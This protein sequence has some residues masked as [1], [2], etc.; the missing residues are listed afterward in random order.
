MHIVPKP[1][2]P[3]SAAGQQRQGGIIVTMEPRGDQ[4]MRPDEAMDRLQRD[5]SGPDLVGERRET[6]VDAF[7]GIA[8]GLTV[9]WL[10]LAEPL[11]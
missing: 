2:L 3:G 5:G 10:M 1:R 4:H 11:K 6:D 9:Q 8:L 7:P